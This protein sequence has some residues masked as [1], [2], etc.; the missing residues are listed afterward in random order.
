NRADVAKTA[1]VQPGSRVQYIALFAGDE[2]A[3]ARFATWLKPQL[4]PNQKLLAANENHPSLQTSLERV[5]HYLGLGSLISVILAGVALAV[6]LKR[7]TSRH[8]DM[9]A[10]M[11]CWGASRLQMLTIYMCLLLYIGVFSILLACV[12][13]YFAQGILEKIL[14]V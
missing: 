2:R 4:A 13:G 8:Y 1:V 6:A 7:F 11:R 3:L 9:V 12:T 10:L 5:Q 14:R